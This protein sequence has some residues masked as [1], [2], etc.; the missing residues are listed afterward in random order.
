M[1]IVFNIVTVLVNIV[2]FVILNIKLYTDRAIMPDGDKQ[3]WHR[4]AID[5]LDAADKR[6]LLYLFILG[7]VVSSISSIMLMFGIK[8]NVVRIVQ[9]I[10]TI[11]S[12]I[13]FIIIL[14]V[15]NATHLKY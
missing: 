15:A 10:S 1:N 4:S 2:Y 7:T 11:A 6:L 12:T 8:N 13:M 5:R 9:L 14:L 3:I